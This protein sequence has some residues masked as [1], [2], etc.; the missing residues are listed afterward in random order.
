MIIEVLYRPG[1][2]DPLCLLLRV[3]PFSE[4]EKIAKVWFRAFRL[5]GCDL[6]LYMLLIGDTVTKI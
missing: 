5:T 6:I 3:C 2:F 4:D 1:T